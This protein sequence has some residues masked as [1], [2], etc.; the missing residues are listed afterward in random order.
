[1]SLIPGVEIEPLYEL[2]WWVIIMVILVTVS[3]ALLLTFV[4][5]LAH[6]MNKLVIRLDQISENAG[7]FVQMG[8]TY[9]KKK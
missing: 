8:M 2:P 9:F 3:N 5:L 4:L 6:K 1:M 7:K